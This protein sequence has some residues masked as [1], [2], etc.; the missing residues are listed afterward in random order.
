MTEC[1]KEEWKNALYNCIIQY[2]PLFGILERHPIY[3]NIITEEWTTEDF[4]NFTKAHSLILARI[5]EVQKE[6][7]QLEKIKEMFE[8]VLKVKYSSY[9]SESKDLNS[10]EI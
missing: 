9:T 1:Y 2:S 7:K 5:D 8:D 6:L 4:K 10:N 3:E